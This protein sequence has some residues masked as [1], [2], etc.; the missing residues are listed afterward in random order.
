MRSDATTE[1]PHSSCT[2]SLLFSQCRSSWK[3]SR[4]A[5]RGLG[6]PRSILGCQVRRLRVLLHERVRVVTH[7]GHRTDRPGVVRG[8]PGCLLRSPPGFS[9]VFF[10]VVI[11]RQV[12]TIQT[13]Q[14]T[15]E[16]PQTQFFGRV[17]ALP[18]CGMRVGSASSRRRCR[19]KFRQGKG[20]RAPVVARGFFRGCG[21]A[22]CLAGGGAPP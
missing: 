16:V 14:K 21:E 18:T 9:S 7:V 20:L 6:I 10:P 13:V 17:V 15:E 19:G 5:G 3:S 22:L 11:P 1:V 2:S 8:D 12:P 4:I